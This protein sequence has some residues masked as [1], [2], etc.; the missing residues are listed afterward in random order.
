MLFQMVVY[1]Y[2]SR[3]ILQVLG[4]SDYGIYDVVGGVVGILVFLNNSMAVATQRYITFALGRK[5]NVFLN[6]VF[7]AS[8]IAHFCL[9]FLV[10]LVGETIGL[11]YITHYMVLPAE[12]LPQ[13]VSVFHCSL[14]TAVVMIISV[15]YNA[16]IIA[17]EKMTAF[18]AITILDVTLKLLIVLALPYVNTDKL[19]TYAILLVLEALVVRTVYGLYCRYRF[20]EMHFIWHGVGRSLFGEILKFAGWSMFGNLALVCNV[21]GLNLVLNAVGGPIVNAGRGV[22]FQAQ[23]AITA[24][25]ASF[26]TAI[27][28]QITKSY[29]KGDVAEMNTLILRGSK[30]SFYLMLFIAIPFILQTD[31]LLSLWLH[32][33]PDYAVDFTRLLLCVSMIDCIS[34]S[35]M[36]GVAATGRIKRYQITIGLVLLCSLPL[37]I[38]F[39]NLGFPVQSVFVA[40]IIIYI[41]AEIIRCFLCQNLYDFRIKAFLKRVLLPIFIVS[42]ISFIPPFVCYCLMDEG[43]LKLLVLTFVS[44]SSVIATV[45]ALGLEQSER[46]FVHKK[47]LSWIHK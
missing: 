40:Q 45:Y 10:I 16:S 22:A 44:V 27:N 26:Q 35:M 9:A 3:V 42:V 30:F 34:N 43:I 38:L 32:R 7:S 41:I 6:R 24:F 47:I 2:T 37:A 25:I 1:L 36:V 28:P 4:V 17:H 8:I 21:Q 39:V 19:V 5:D 11:F 23:T 33:V 18:A 20:R 46:E 14:L 15:P 29:A 13:A 12:R 31:M